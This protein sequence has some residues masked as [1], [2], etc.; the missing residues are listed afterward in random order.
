[1]GRFWYVT[2][3]TIVDIHNVVSAFLEVRFPTIIGL[4]KI[5]LS[6]SDKNIDKICRKYDDVTL[7]CNLQSKLVPISA[8]SEV[9][10]K[11]LHQQRFINYEEGTDFIELA[12][13][14]EGYPNNDLKVMDDKTR[15]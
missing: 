9:F 7:F 11:K 13:D 3:L 5:D 6:E 14:N 8:L 10:L 15:A 12:E 4:N 1:M 2:V